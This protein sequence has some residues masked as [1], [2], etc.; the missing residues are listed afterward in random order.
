MMAARPVNWRGRPGVATSRGPLA[1]TAARDSASHGASSQGSEDEDQDDSATAPPSPA[2]RWTRWLGLVFAVAVLGLLAWAAR[3]VDW[4]AVLQAL[5]AMPLEVVAAA[6]GAALLSYGLYSAYD[7]I[8][9]AWIGHRLAWWRVLGVTAISY[10]FNLNLGMI[11]GGVG[12]RYRL[13]SKLGLRGGQIGRILTM[14]VVTNWLGYGVLAGGVFLFRQIRP[15]ADWHVTGA[16]LQLLGGALW[17]LVAAYLAMC[18]WSRRRDFTVRGHRIRLPG[19]GM[20][21]AQVALSC[22]NWLAIAL[23][24]YLL[25]RGQIP[26]GLVLGTSL[27]AAVAGVVARLPAGLGV[28][29]A[30]FVTV[31]ASRLP[32]ASVLATMLVYRA[33]YYLLPLLLATAGH[34]WIEAR[35]SRG[36]SPGARPAA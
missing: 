20:A 17:L 5:R 15:P 30:V 10:A 29:E 3:R 2:Q 32:Q 11:V 1:S 14:S 22:A 4:P 26:F 27:V 21:L 31:L 18:G 34:L 7:L 23:M 8:G 25:L 28:I 13:Y 36:I 9:R 33:L 6:A 16:T 19:L 12:I 24:L 35:A